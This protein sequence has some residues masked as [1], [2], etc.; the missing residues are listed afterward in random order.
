MTM[1]GLAKMSGIGQARTV[2][3]LRLVWSGRLARCHCVGKVDH[4]VLR[5]MDR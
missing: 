4:K 3:I 2:A 5:R 1:L